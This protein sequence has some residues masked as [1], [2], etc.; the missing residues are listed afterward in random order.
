MRTTVRTRMRIYAYHPWSSWGPVRFEMC[1]A[2]RCSRGTYL[3]NVQ[4][5]GQLQALE[6]A[7]DMVVRVHDSMGRDQTVARM[8]S[9]LLV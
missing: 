8:F 4:V 6:D 9:A 3:F 7:D 2:S 5:G 1:E